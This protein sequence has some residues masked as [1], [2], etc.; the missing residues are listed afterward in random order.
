MELEKNKEIINIKNGEINNLQLE[1]TNKNKKINELNEIITQKNN[2]INKLNEQLN[3]LKTESI[4]YNFKEFLPGE[5][6]ISILFK[7]NDQKI[8]YSLPCKNTTTFVKLEEKLYE[9]Y[10][11]YKETDNYFLANGNRIKRFKT[12]K[13]NQIKNGKPVI[14][15]KGE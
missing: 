4:N 12:I 10:P 14:L 7:S 9:E 1:L 2:E 11:E 13:E 15:I 3:N 8:E 6:V 5:E